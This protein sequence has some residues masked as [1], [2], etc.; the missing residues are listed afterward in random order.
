MDLEN[1]APN[2]GSRG[3]RKRRGRGNASGLGRTSG[4][5]EK[6]QKARAGGGTRPGFE[7]GQM[8]LYRRLPK[9]GFRSRKEM[10]GLNQYNIVNIAALD[11]FDNETVVDLDALKSIGYG[12][13]ARKRAGIKILGRGEL[14]KKLTV[15]VHAVSAG[16]RKAIEDA[17]G[18]VELI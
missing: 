15:K 10:L 13:K 16:A 12:V 4:K 6:G 2:K 1:L 18:S 7:G 8:P 14:S 5:G 9:S 17:G 3:D 11:K